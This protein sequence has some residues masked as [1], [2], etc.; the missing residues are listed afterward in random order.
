[1]LS[2]VILA[3]FA[4]TDDLFGVGHGRGPIEALLERLAVKRSWGRVVPACSSV[5]LSEQ[6]LS[7]LECNTLMLNPE[8]AFFIERP[9]DKHEGFR[10]EREPP[11][12]GHVF[13]QSCVR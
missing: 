10:L 2:C 7:L 11:G 4:S 12:L 1:M 9:V 8:G 13:E 5:H 6:L 3:A